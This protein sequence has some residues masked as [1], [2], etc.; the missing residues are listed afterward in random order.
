MSRRL[1]LSASAN[2]ASTEPACTEQKTSAVVVPSQQLVAKDARSP[3]DR[4]IG[5]SLF[6]HEGIL[7][8]PVKQLMSLR[9]DN[10]GLHI[11]DMAVDEARRDQA[12][13][14]VGD[15]GVRRQAGSQRG[16]RTDCLDGAVA[17]DDETIGLMREG[18]S[19]VGEKRIV[20]AKDQRPPQGAERTAL[21]GACMDIVTGTRASRPSR[22]A[23]RQRLNPY[24]MKRPPRP[25]STPP[26][27][28]RGRARET[29]TQRAVRLGK[30]QGGSIPK[31]LRKAPVHHLDLSARGR[32]ADP[33]RRGVQIA[34]AGERREENMMVARILRDQDDARNPTRHIGMLL[35][36]RIPEV[37][38]QVC[39]Q[40][41]KPTRGLRR[42][43]Q[44]PARRRP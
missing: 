9:A 22:F 12:A 24:A 21:G 41:A 19:G 44:M 10:P 6:G 14:M 40:T 8:E 42:R 39:W 25:C 4:R 18:C 28:Q 38:R 7:F 16:I 43:G 15:V 30:S 3:G 17:A 11:V 36:Y 13:R 1:R 37:L 20:A 35:K 32:S 29:A 23:A 33:A 27:A 5:K 31:W 2:S 34:H 26:P